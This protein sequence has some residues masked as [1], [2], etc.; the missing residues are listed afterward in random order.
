MQLQRKG[1]IFWPVRLKDKTLN[2]I[3]FCKEANKIS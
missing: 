2:R 1:Q 3:V